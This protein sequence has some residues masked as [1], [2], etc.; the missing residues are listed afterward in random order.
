MR[1]RHW[2]SYKITF[3]KNLKQNWK[4]MKIYK[5]VSDKEKACDDKLNEMAQYYGKEINDLRNKLND[6]NLTIEQSNQAKAQI[7][8]NLKKVLMRELW[9]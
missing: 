2:D 8:E 5:R 6:A 4:D 7:Q 3:F 9:Q 1:K